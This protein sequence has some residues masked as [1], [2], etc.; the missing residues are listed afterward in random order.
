MSS[1][2][3]VAL[4][5]GV[6]GAKLALGLSKILRPGELTVVA[7]TADDFTHLGLH[8]S[9]D[10]DTVMYTLAEV[11]NQ[12]T[13]W[14]R[15][16]ETWSFISALK[17]LGGEDW[18]QLGDKDLAT[19][20]ERTRRLAEGET[21]SRVTHDLCKH[22]GIE[23]TIVP[24]SDDSIQTKVK[25]RSGE[26]SFQHY[27]VRDKCEPVVTGFHF[28]GLNEAAPSV[29]FQEALTS[30][31]LAAVVICPSNPFVSVDPI[32]SIPAIK[33][34]LPTLDV[35]IVA[36]SPIVGGMAIKGPAAKMMAELGMPSTTTSIAKYYSGLVDG[37]VVDERD[38]D[39]EA[40][41]EEFDMSV[42]VTNTVMKSLEDRVNLARETIDL[43]LEL[44]RKKT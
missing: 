10:L 1:G 33:E 18:F 32:L 14:G 13:G 38:R 39:H 44:S 12:K 19:H 37:L 29:G 6:G 17:A 16:G 24:M 43:I 27:F 21:L 3:I 36:V 11:A 35:P 15:E 31:N 9:P 40:S 5:G 25:T 22:L 30:P 28:E 42:K 8:I 26:L 7:N 41:I 4:S 20:I 34:R 23:H 2:H